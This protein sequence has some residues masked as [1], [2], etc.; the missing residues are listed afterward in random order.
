MLQFLIFIA[1]AYIL[2]RL[3]MGEFKKKKDIKDKKKENLAA[4]GVMT[5]DPVCGTYIP[6]DGD[7]RVKQG[8]KVHNF[9]SY[10]C[11]DKFLKQLA[12]K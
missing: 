7:I 3:V 12:D 1:A 9:C 2:Y 10:E 6:V 5:K 4:T 8:D 11:R